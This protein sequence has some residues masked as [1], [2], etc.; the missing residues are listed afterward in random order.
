MNLSS[1]GTKW[2]SRFSG[3]DTF[4]R[5]LRT[6]HET[7]DWDDQPADADDAAAAW[8]GTH[9][10]QQS[11]Q[12][13]EVVGEAITLEKDCSKLSTAATNGTS[14]ADELK[15][16]TTAANGGCNEETNNVVRKVVQRFEEAYGV[17]VVMAAECGSRVFGWGSVDSDFDVRAVYVH[18]PRDYVVLRAKERQTSACYNV[19]ANLA[20][21]RPI[22]ITLQ[23]W[24]LPHYLD[25]LQGSNPSAIDCLYSP[26]QY[27]R[28]PPA[29]LATLATQF[30]AEHVSLHKFVQSRLSLIVTVFQN[31]VGTVLP[32]LAK[33]RYNKKQA[34]QSTEV[35]P[36]DTVARVV[37]PKTYVVVLRCILDVAHTLRTARSDGAG[38]AFPPP[39]SIEESWAAYV[40]GGIVGGEEAEMLLPSVTAWLEAYLARKRSGSKHRGV[41]T[42]APP[43]EAVEAFAIAQHRVLSEEVHKQGDLLRRQPVSTAYLNE[44]LRSVVFDEGCT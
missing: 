14:H 18:K 8:V 35:P 40:S 33:K 28:E 3:G 42:Q 6:R 31:H 21:A 34:Q 26:V 41:V 37:P 20:T 10:Q 19:W 15:F 17:R 24:D 23:C 39:F 7:G 11:R 38:A 4:V 36:A 12:Y 13:S 32:H 44:V 27:V 2:C 30:G 43:S 25:L 16:D 1:L 22:D 29:P 9:S 5:Y